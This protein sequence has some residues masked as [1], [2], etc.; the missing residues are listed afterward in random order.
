MAGFD[1][2]VYHK[3]K[4]VFIVRFFFLTTLDTSLVI[5]LGYTVRLAPFCPAMA[6]RVTTHLS[7]Q[8]ERPS[9]RRSRPLCFQL[10]E[11][12]RTHTALK[13]H[14]RGSGPATER[15]CAGLGVS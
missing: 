15:K 8:L 7:Q 2:T 6:S 12:L 13:D 4:E 10:S 1:K 5:T 11:A 3:P 9:S 14:S